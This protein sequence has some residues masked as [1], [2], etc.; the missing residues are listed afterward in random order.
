M[1]TQLLALTLTIL[2]ALLS[3]LPNLCNAAEINNNFYE[4]KVDGAKLRAAPSKKANIYEE[5]SWG[6]TFESTGAV[7][8]K[9]GNEFIELDYVVNGEDVKAYIYSGNVVQHKFHYYSD[10]SFDSSH[11]LQVCIVCGFAS[12]KSVDESVPIDSTT[13]YD[14]LSEIFMGNYAEEHTFIGTLA[15]IA[16]SELPGVGT[17]TDF[18]DLLYD[19]TS[20]DAE[21]IDLGID[22]LAFLPLI[23]TVKSMRATKAI[24][25]TSD[26]IDDEATLL[27]WGRWEDFPKSRIGEK[28]YAYID[29]YYFSDHAIKHTYPSN[30][31]SKSIGFDGG[32]VGTGKIVDI[33]QAE[34]RYGIP[35]TYIADI[36]KNVPPS[37][38]KESNGITRY[39]TESNGISIVTEKAED[40]SDIVVTI[41][42]KK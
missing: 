41:M 11:E 22:L 39:I 26:I 37:A 3:M 15:R 6:F 18:Q 40:D 32:K 13:T 31:Y 25:Y 29:G 17:V 5:L 20:E 10:C 30:I 33:T 1:K 28:E 36:L 35:P 4:V 12:L 34:A 42:T 2:L 23:S 19:L 24:K 8:S 27:K 14:I 21:L 38:T 16:V 7:T 9:A